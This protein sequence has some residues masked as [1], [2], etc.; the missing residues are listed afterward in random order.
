MRYFLQFTTTLTIILA[1]F[2]TVSSQ[3]DKAPI[4]A[5]VDI[6]KDVVTSYDVLDNDISAFH[7]I[8]EYLRT[9]VAFPFEELEYRNTHNVLVE[10]VSYTH[11]TLP[12]T[13]YV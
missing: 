9:K 8:T 2:F 7:Q 6:N 10:A 13:P 3:V 11:L 12:T 5:S 4:Y 1:S